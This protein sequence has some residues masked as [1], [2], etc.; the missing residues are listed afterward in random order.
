MWTGETVVVVG[1][2][3]SLTQAQVD[4]CRGRAR[5]IV[6]NNAYKLAPWADWLHGCDTKWWLWHSNEGAVAFPGIRTTLCDD[7]PPAWARYLLNTGV[8]GFDDDP[9]CCRTGRNGAYQAI[10]CAIHAGAAK[11]VL[12]GVDMQNAPDGRSHWHGDHPD[13]LQADYSTWMAPTFETLM[14]TLAARGVEVLNS[15]PG[16]ALAAFPLVPLEDAI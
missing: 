16:S 10:H 3:P 4:H 7:V 5:T 8:I 2:G 11:V 14:P 15:S 12:L 13:G 6:V 9:S 1:G